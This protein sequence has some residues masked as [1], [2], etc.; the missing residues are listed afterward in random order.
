MKKL[1]YSL[2]TYT[3]LFFLSNPCILM[4][5]DMSIN[6]AK[7]NKLR[8]L[9]SKFK[10][11][12][13]DA[14]KQA[15]KQAKQHN[16][17]IRKA[18]PDGRTIEL[19]FVTENG[20]PFYYQ[21]SNVDAADTISTDEVWKNGSA[22]L[23][24][25]GSG[26]TI[27]QWDTGGVLTTHQELIHRVT[28]KDF[29]ATIDHHATHVAGT[30]I[31]SGIDVDAQGMSP[32]A[33]LD[34]YDWNSDSGEMAA[35]AAEGLILSNHS[36]DAATGWE[37][38]VPIGACQEEWTWF[39]HPTQ[40][41]EYKFGYYSTKAAEWDDISYNAPEYLIVKSA[42]NNRTDSGPGD[43]HDY[44]IFYGATFNTSTS[45]R[46]ADCQ[47]D[48]YDCIPTPGTAKNILTVGAVN[49][50]PGGYPESD[51]TSAV[52]MTSYSSW[53]PTDDGRIKPDLVA[54][55]TSL[56]S[57]TSSSGTA[58]AIS[59][60]TS[61]AAPTVTGSLLLLQQHYKNLN[62]DSVMQGATLKALVFHTADEAGPT[63][64]P[65]YM[66][67]WGLMNT[68]SAAQVIS[69]N[70]STALIKEESYA[71]ATPY[72]LTV[73]ATGDVPLIVTNVWTDP[74]G[75][76]PAF[77]VDPTDII[78]VNDL[79]MNINDGTT[80]WYPYLLDGQNPDAAATTGDNDV[81][82]VEQ[83]V[84]ANPIAGPYTITVS[85]EGEISG[86]TQDFSL[87]I[88]GIEVNDRQAGSKPMPWLMLLLKERA[89][90]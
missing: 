62:N 44:C 89:S 18:F 78:L 53:G 50:L 54:N 9:A 10:Q 20:L 24:L 49:D 12:A 3:V 68:K 37:W 6:E 1:I 63:D 65:D 69:G 56:Y 59:N 17:L 86:E 75:T 73:Q 11:N 74:A 38:N 26:M 88:T 42:G 66:F 48:G 52:L 47:P 51:G 7:R 5:D 41:E 83:I 21:T 58:Y 23:E 2:L 71:P 76:V 80:T 25:D 79:D 19:Q 60:G 57:S 87:V 90:E 77:G 32:A 43:G 55:G 33:S 13:Q 40:S 85:H 82:N 72:T 46:D 28:Q 8:S 31:A 61:M 4:A 16:W 29:P 70:N 14:Q 30:L 39:G 34:A 45:P 35:A 22:G 15:R 64:G 81:D 36:Y 67:G 84:I 27:G